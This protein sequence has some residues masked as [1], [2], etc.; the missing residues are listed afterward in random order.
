MVMS[1]FRDHPS[2]K[3]YMAGVEYG[4]KYPNFSIQEA[5]SWAEVVKDGIRRVED[6]GAFIDGFEASK[7]EN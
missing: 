7:G 4:K 1:Y 5:L 3:S 6:L 2:Y